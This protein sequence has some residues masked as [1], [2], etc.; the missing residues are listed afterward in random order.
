MAAI[1]KPLGVRSRMEPTTFDLHRVC[2]VPH[3][4]A[5]VAWKKL[6]TTTYTIPDN[7]YLTKL[8]VESASGAPDVE[9]L[10][11]AVPGSRTQPRLQELP[12][13]NENYYLHYLNNFY[14]AKV[15]VDSVYSTLTL[16][17]VSS[18]CSRC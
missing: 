16:C 4:I 18:W 5:G 12:R 9:A 2:S 17:R 13:K 6:Q 8:A 1:P 10:P 14:L 3:Q 15:A 7:T 11:L